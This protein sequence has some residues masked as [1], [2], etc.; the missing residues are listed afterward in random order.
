MKREPIQYSRLLI[1]VGLV[2]LLFADLL[3]GLPDGA[4]V[5][6]GAIVMAAAAVVHFY[7][8]EPRAG[9]GWLVFGAALGLA[10]VVDP[11]SDILYL[12]AFA[13]LLLSGLALIASQRVIGTNEA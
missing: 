5:A 13:L 7:G 8:G 11:R 4:F 12:L 2:P 10:A 6:G 3:F 9:A 1:L